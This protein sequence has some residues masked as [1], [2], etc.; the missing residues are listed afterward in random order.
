MPPSVGSVMRCPFHPDTKPSFSYFQENNG[1]GWWEC[2][3]G[4]GKGDAIDYIQTKFEMS[5]PD[6]ISLY[7]KMAH[8]FYGGEL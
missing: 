6:S 3:A 1:H 4:C 7:L 5:Q 2:W 8:F